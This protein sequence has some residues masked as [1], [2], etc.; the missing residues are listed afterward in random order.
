MAAVLFSS[1]YRGEG[2]IG[3]NDEWMKYWPR[4][5]I[6]DTNIDSDGQVSTPRRLRAKTFKF[7]DLVKQLGQKKKIKSLQGRSLFEYISVR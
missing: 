1:Y 5:H 6:V 4:H 7:F 2:G 3:K